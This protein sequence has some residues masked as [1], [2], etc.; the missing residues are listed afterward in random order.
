MIFFRIGGEFC[1]E[2]EDFGLIAAKVFFYHRIRIIERIS[3]IFSSKSP[4]ISPLLNVFRGYTSTEKL[5]VCEKCADN[6]LNQ[7]MKSACSIAHRSFNLVDSEHFCIVSA[8]PGQLETSEINALQRFGRS[9][10]RI[11]LLFEKFQV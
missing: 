7:S 3:Y 2:F 6:V 8:H 9:R 1:F 11:I 10:R 4:P 5:S